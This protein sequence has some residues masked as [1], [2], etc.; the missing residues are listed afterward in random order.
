[1]YKLSIGYYCTQDTRIGVFFS[2]DELGTTWSFEALRIPEEI[3]GFIA[4]K[5]TLLVRA[6][7]AESAVHGLFCST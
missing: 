4:Y 3:T 5:W 2:F 1:M 7:L 6:C